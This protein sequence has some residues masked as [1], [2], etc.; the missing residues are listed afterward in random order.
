ML[1]QNEII[2]I[3]LVE[4]WKRGNSP[5]TSNNNFQSILYV[6]Y[7]LQKRTKLNAM[8][9]LIIIIPSSLPFTFTSWVQEY[10]RYSIYKKGG[11]D[12]F[13]LISYDTNTLLLCAFE[14][15]GKNICQNR[16]A[17]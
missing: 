12:L 7:F 16:M 9:V 5:I 2:S 6:F 13:Y 15:G 17:S 8:E 3:G 11:R 1:I 4:F 14:K 10:H